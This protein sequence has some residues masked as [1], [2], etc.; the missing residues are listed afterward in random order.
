MEEGIERVAQAVDGNA[1]GIDAV[2]EEQTGVK[3]IL[4]GS[5]DKG[6]LITQVGKNESRGK[7]NFAL[8]IGFVVIVAI[9][10]I[11]LVMTIAS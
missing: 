8:I 1:D 5:D 7:M 3:K 6:G 10:L 11:G 2:C 9:A 4:H